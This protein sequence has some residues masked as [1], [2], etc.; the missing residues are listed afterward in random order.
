MT[1]TLNDYVKVSQSIW[2]G[3]LCPRAI[4]YNL[5]PVITQVLPTSVLKQ[6]LVKE[7]GD[8]QCHNSLFLLQPLQR[9]SL[10]FSA[11]VPRIF[12]LYI[13]KTPLQKVHPPIYSWAGLQIKD[14]YPDKGFISWNS[15]CGPRLTTQSSPAFQG[16]GSNRNQFIWKPLRTSRPSQYRPWAFTPA[17][18]VETIQ[19]R[20]GKALGMF[21]FWIQWIICYLSRKSTTPR[22]IWG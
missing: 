16:R 4:C 11:S 10:N 5:N 8:R 2:W 9:R 17:G 3:G 22:C 21:V 15:S 1:S 18:G 12:N 13:C 14:F 6:R 19:S 7:G 20:S